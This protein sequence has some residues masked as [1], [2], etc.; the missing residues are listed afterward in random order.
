MV[1]TVINRGS[2]PLSSTKGVLHEHPLLCRWFR[3]YSVACVMP[4]QEKSDPVK[5]W[6]AFLCICVG[7]STRFNRYRELKNTT[8]AACAVGASTDIRI[9]LHCTVSCH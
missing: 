8:I 4:R 3:C 6:V 7:L 9:D 5:N 2:T 1:L